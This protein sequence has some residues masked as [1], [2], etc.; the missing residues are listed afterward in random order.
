MIKDYTKKVIAGLTALTLVFGL[1][2][3][4]DDW[5]DYPDDYEDDYDL[6]EYEED[7]EEDY[8]APQET[9]H[10]YGD[11][12]NLSADGSWTVFV[13]LCGTDLESEGGMGT[14]DLQEMMDAQGSENVR[15]VVQTGGTYQWYN[16]IVDPDSLQR[17]LI[18]SGSMELVD[19]GSLEAMG[20]EETLTDFVSWGLTN[21]ASEHNGLIFWDHGGGSIS[22]V[23]VDE[24]N[25]CDM[26]SLREISNA[27]GAAEISQKFDFIGFDACL[28]GTIETANIL[29]PYALYMYGSEE[30]EP[31]SG[32]DYSTI[33]S[34]LSE[35]PGADGAALGKV[36][37]DS[38]L[39]ACAA[40]NDDDLTTLSVIDLSRL[41]DLI[42][43]LDSFAGEL[44]AA[45]GDEASK[46]SIIRGFESAENFGGNNK[47]DGYTNM[48]DLGAIVSNCASYAQGA[49]D[50]ISALGNAVVYSV[51]GSVHRNAGGLAIYYPLSIQGSEELDIFNDIS[52]S[53]SYSDFIGNKTEGYQGSGA[54]I[55]GEETGESPVITFVNEPAIDD[56][57]VY[58]F[59]LDTNGINAAA[60]IYALVYEYTPEGDGLIELGQTYDINGDW[61][62]GYFY[63]A[64]D[65]YWLSLSDGQNL[66]IY[67]A[68][69]TDDAIIY[70]SPVTVN[71]EETNLRLMQNMQTGEVTVEGTW[72]GI[73]ENGYAAREIY[74]LQSGDVIVPRYFA[75]EIEGDEEYEYIGGEYTVS[76]PVEIYYDVMEDGDYLYAFCIDDIYGDY[77]L[78]DP[79][80]FN[81]EGDE[82]SFYTE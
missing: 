58:S 41:G 66:A 23:C 42:S 67:I 16:D 26:L 54:V 13:Y 64:F 70:S 61:D 55:S 44:C 60:D 46:A 52:V 25:D 20:A 14:G 72:E 28:M 49:D 27:L 36:V 4:S 82:I 2:A 51:T 80:T 7:Y 57:G 50:V 32:W 76:G 65:G 48:V 30:T 40:D 62:T 3:C 9:E 21:Y 6:G 77:Y 63:D 74:K 11:V 59:K 45:S 81:I 29:E 53:Q 8:D 68:D 19:E 73:D 39:Q 18:Q 56:E 33:G 10:D 12:G 5:E 79:A 78:A 31:G 17:Y 38:F 47:V 43:S 24:L 69:V 75:F 71:G 15:F 1:T 22:G 34:F 35:Y 37:C